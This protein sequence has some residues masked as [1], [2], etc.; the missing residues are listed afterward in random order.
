MLLKYSVDPYSFM[1][2]GH[3]FSAMFYLNIAVPMP[4]LNANADTHL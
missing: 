3:S 1:L 4:M 2:W